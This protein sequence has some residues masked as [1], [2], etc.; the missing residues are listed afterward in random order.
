MFEETFCSGDSIF[1]KA[2]PRV[3]LVLALMFIIAI[4][5]N[6]NLTSAI[7]IFSSTILLIPLA[8]LSLIK[9]LKRLMV[10]NSF[11]LFLW[12]FLP[13]STPGTPIF[14]IY[15]FHATIEGIMQSLLITLKANSAILVIICFINTT[16][17]PLLGHAL[18]RL[19]LPSKFVLLFL[20]TYRYIGVISEEFTRLMNAAKV[21]N[22]SP[23]TNL[24]TYKTISYMLAMVLIKSYERGKRVYNAMILRGFNGKFYSLHESKLST[25]DVVISFLSLFIIAISHLNYY[26]FAFLAKHLIIY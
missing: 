21:R 3:K 11:I 12:L 19:K 17:I 4:I 6:Y 10:V 14:H 20:L 8:Q 7:F 13:F 22:F 16:S 15:K 18:Y 24:H 1:H 2:D 25:N 5:L 26:N 23:K 9:V